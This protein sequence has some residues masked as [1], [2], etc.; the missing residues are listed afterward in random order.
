MNNS[1]CD[2]FTERNNEDMYSE[3]LLFHA[4]VNT[5]HCNRQERITFHNSNAQAALVF[6]QVRLRPLGD[7]EGAFQ[8]TG[9]K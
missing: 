4:K 2:G 9:M 6:T 3:D 5:S 8:G 7:V 1:V